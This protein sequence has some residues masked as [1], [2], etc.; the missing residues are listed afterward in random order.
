M[1]GSELPSPE[2]REKTVRDEVLLEVRDLTIEAGGPAPLG[3]PA[4]PV[5]RVAAEPRDRRRD[6]RT[7]RR[8]RPPPARP[9]CRSTSTPARSSASP[10]SRA[11][12]RP[13][14]SRRSWACAPPTGLVLARGRRPRRRQHARPAPARHRLHPR[15][16]PARRHG[17]VV[18]AVGERAARPPGRAAVRQRRLRSTAA[19]SARARRAIVEE[20]DVRTPGIEV[21]RSRCRAATSRS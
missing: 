2:T 13:S 3:G 19:R 12:A 17:A 11:T 5:R 20:F 1:V 8:H 21:P 4:D 15:G 14:S 9:T 16:P 7:R 18:P 10:A 6:H